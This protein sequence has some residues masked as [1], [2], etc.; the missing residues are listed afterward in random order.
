[1]LPWNAE[2][3]E[4][5]GTLRA[6]LESQGTPLGSLDTLIAAHALAS[7]CTLVTNDKAFGRVAEIAVQDWTAP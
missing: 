6:T 4:R 7:R 1:V 5:Y 2:A 3:A